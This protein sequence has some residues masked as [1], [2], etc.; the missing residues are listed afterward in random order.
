MEDLIKVDFN[1]RFVIEAE[2]GHVIGATTASGFPAT[3][4]VYV[5]G[6][7]EDTGAGTI[8]DPFRTIYRALEEV[9]LN[10]IMVDGIHGY[11]GTIDLDGKKLYNNPGVDWRYIDPDTSPIRAGA[12]FDANPT[13]YYDN[14]GALAP[15]GFYMPQLNGT[16]A[17]PTDIRIYRFRGEIDQ[18]S[19]LPIWSLVTPF[20]ILDYQDEIVNVA[21]VGAPPYLT[22]FFLFTETLRA[23]YDPQLDKILIT[24]VI[25]L[26]DETAPLDVVHTPMAFTFDLTD[27]V[28]HAQLEDNRQDIAGLKLARFFDIFSGVA[29]KIGPNVFKYEIISPAQSFTDYHIVNCRASNSF[30]GFNSTPL[31]DWVTDS[32]VVAR[33]NNAGMDFARLFKRFN[34]D[35]SSNRGGELHHA[36]MTKNGH[37]W[38]HKDKS[39]NVSTLSKSQIIDQA[40]AFDDDEANLNSFLGNFILRSHI[41]SFDGTTAPASVVITNIATGSISQAQFIRDFYE[42]VYPE[43][44]EIT[45]GELT[46]LNQLMAFGVY[47][48]SQQN[49]MSEKN[50]TQHTD[51]PTGGGN[52]YSPQGFHVVIAPTLYASQG[53]NRHPLFFN[54]PLIKNINL[55]ITP[56]VD[57]TRK[58]FVH[59]ISAHVDLVEQSDFNGR[60]INHDSA[61]VSYGVSEKCSFNKTGW[62]V[63]NIL[64]ALDLRADNTIFLSIGIAVRK[65]RAWHTD[66]FK[67]VNA[68]AADETIEN[69]IVS[70]CSGQFIN[71]T[72]LAMTIKDSVIREQLNANVI[73]ILAIKQGT[74]LSRNPFFK[75]IVQPFNLKLQ[76]TTKGDPL[77]SPAIGLTTTPSAFGGVRE[78]GAFDDFST[79]KS[80]FETFEVI[81]PWVADIRGERQSKTNKVETG[82]QPTLALSQQT[83]IVKFDWK[84]PVTDIERQFIHRLMS[85][86]TTKVRFHLKPIEFPGQFLEGF[87]VPKTN[88]SNKQAIIDNLPSKLNITVNFK[89]PDATVEINDFI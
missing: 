40:L 27:Y 65:T 8:G 54:S 77:D 71:A 38:T 84:L 64:G 82:S 89:A 18:N 73:P 78:A 63:D 3:D 32:I 16:L 53:H 41:L 13:T 5:S 62:G 28:G 45:E 55:T 43:L 69:S 23:W 21:G 15:D 30:M 52:L 57:P 56:A 48:G 26:R 29:S 51:V 50:F 85:A 17:T 35:H 86:S 87:I 47:G 33:N 24:A 10:I 12:D 7:G 25:S 42:E 60:E 2:N 61:V 9:E 49:Y 39:G 83:L 36:S 34:T 81:A 20:S 66:I 22:N 46:G 75:S 59:G 88:Y 58:D 68:C 37:Q 79:V 70:D 11:Y 1:E 44:A 6:T 19:E 74:V 4:V 67:G 31:D 80:F 76:S 14:G 72:G